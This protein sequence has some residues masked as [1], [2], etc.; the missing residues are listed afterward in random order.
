MKIDPKFPFLLTSLT[1]KI[2]FLLWSLPPL[3]LFLRI[4]FHLRERGKRRS[5]TGVCGERMGHGEGKEDA[6]EIVGLFVCLIVRV[7]CGKGDREKERRKE[8]EG[9]S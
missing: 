6:F 2:P 7:V 3:T 9:K 1:P 5:R 8:V 4:Y